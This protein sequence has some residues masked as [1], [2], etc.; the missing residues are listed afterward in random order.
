MK[1]IKTAH[2]RASDGK[3][4][5]QASVKSVKIDQVQIFSD[6]TKLHSCTA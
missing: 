6:K 4:A 2:L 3:T 5:L 1:I